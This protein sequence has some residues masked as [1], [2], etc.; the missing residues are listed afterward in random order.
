M[1]VRKCIGPAIEKAGLK[2]VF[3]AESAGLTSQQLSY[4]IAGRRKLDSNEL[5]NICAILRMTPNELLGFGMASE[6]AEKGA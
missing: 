2:K 4:I 5:V 3:V 1:D 6:G